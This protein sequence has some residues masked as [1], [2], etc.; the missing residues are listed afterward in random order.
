MAYRHFHDKVSTVGGIMIVLLTI[1]L[2]SY[3]ST[4]ADITNRGGLT[5]WTEK[6]VED[7]T[8]AG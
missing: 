4:S 7:I 6:I 8:D 3:P 5:S 2:E 1:T